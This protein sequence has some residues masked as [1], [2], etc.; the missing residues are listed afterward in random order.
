MQISKYTRM[1]KATWL[2][3]VGVH[4]RAAC[5]R[6]GRWRHISW[7]NKFY[8]S[9]EVWMKKAV[10]PEERRAREMEEEYLGRV[11]CKLFK[12]KREDCAQGVEIVVF[13]EQRGT[14]KSWRPQEV[15]WLSQCH[16]FCLL[17]WFINERVKLQQIHSSQVQLY[18]PGNVLSKTL[19]QCI[20]W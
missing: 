20:L 17:F 18:T 10:W 1:I 2:D 4:E 16:L 6:M 12:I 14:M 5:L 7:E 3:A 8:T 15:K 13:Q 19:L 9:A 11:H